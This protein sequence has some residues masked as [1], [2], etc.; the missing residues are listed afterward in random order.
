MKSA[1]ENPASE[2]NQKMSRDNERAAF[3][4]RME[5]SAQFGECPYCGE[6]VQLPQIYCCLEHE[7]KRSLE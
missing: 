4:A 6:A 7:E 3:A 5:A 1:R 2:E